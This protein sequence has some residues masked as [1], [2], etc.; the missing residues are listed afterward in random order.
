MDTPLVDPLVCAEFKQGLPNSSGAPPLRHFFMIATPRFLTPNPC[1]DSSLAA[2]AVF[3]VE[4]YPTKRGVRN[5]DPET[6]RETAARM[7]FCVS[8]HSR[9]LKKADLHLEAKPLHA[10]RSQRRICVLH[11]ALTLFLQATQ[12]QPSSM[13]V[14]C[15][16]VQQ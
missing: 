13:S 9:R 5:A 15:T 3:N 7:P 11:P 16:F 2:I 8:A 1:F 10:Q 12:D 4:R 6:R 14:D